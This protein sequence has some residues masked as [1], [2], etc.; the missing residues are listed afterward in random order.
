MNQYSQRVFL[1]LAW[2]VLAGCTSMSVMEQKDGPPDRPVDVSAVPEPVPRHE[3]YSKYGNPPQYEVFGKTYQVKDSA[4][5]YVEQGI[6]SWYGTKFHGKRTSSGEPYDMYAMTAAH[7]TLPLPTYAEVRN[8]D[9]G[10]TVV[11][12]INDRGPFHDDRII[13]LSYAAAHKLGIA[14]RGTGRVEVRAIIPEREAVQAGVQVIA[15]PRADIPQA[16]RLSPQVYLQVASFSDRENLHRVL[17]RLLDAAID[18]IHILQG[19]TGENQPVYRLRVGP[20]AD[21]AAA[22][23]IAERLLG[24]GLGTP[25]I[26]V[27]Q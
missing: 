23:L 26:I 25:Y 11:V 18:R 16:E 19:S 17:G 7:K 8:L 27:D 1:S 24:L 14:E 5:G 9:N 2:L 12:R 21:R 6:A 3:P 22:S 15:A 13:D 20:M 4:T 10:R